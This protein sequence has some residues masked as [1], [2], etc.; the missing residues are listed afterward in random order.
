M[1]WEGGP[2]NN[3]NLKAY[4]SPSIGLQACWYGNY[5]GDDSIAQSGPI[6][7]STP[8][9][10]LWYPFDDS[11]FELYGWYNGA[12]EWKLSEHQAPWQSK[13][14][15]AGVGCYSWGK[16]YQTTYAMMVNKYN[17]V[18]V[19]WRDTN[20]TSNATDTHPVNSWMNASGAAI[21]GVY[22][23]TS[24]GYTDF[25]ITQMADGSVMGHNITWAAENSSISGAQNFTIRDQ[26]SIRKGL[27]G[28]HLT[29][30]AVPTPSEGR[31]LNI[32][33]QTNGSDIV[34]FSRD[35]YKG[36]FVPTPLVIPDQ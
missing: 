2:L 15:H 33:Y 35:I 13:N 12:T 19:W 1:T 34:V 18:E 21:P 23:S 27:N 5:Y 25:L 36:V 10:N 24:L 29:N 31:D 17:T 32:F 11:K 26:Q 14:T 20:K 6:S 4:D 3:L 9:I 7:E 30:T 28:T 8:G 16:T 22:P